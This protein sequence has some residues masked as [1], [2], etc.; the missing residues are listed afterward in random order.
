MKEENKVFIDIL[1]RKENSNKINWLNAIGYSVKFIYD[2]IED[3]LTIVNYYKESRELE[4]KYKDRSQKIKVHNFTNCQLGNV[5]GKYTSD[6]KIGIGTNLKDNKKDITIINREYRKN[7]M[8]QNQKWYK[9]HCNKDNYEGWM[10]ESSV[11]KGIGC[12]CCNGK[13]VVEGINDITTTAPWLIPYFQGGY[14]EAKLYTKNSGKKIFP[15]CLDCGRVKDKAMSISDIY[16]RHTIGCQCNDKKSYISK[17]V[18]N[19]LEQLKIDFE[20]EKKYDWCNFYNPFKQK[21]TYGIYD[22]VI[23]DMKL[24][25]E[26]DGGW[27]RK[28]NNISGQTKEESEWL[29]NIKDKLAYENG[30]KIIRISDD[31][32]V[33][34]NILDSDLSE[35]FDL[36][37]IDWNKCNEFALSNLIKQVC[38]YWNTNLNFTTKDISEKFNI[39]QFCVIEYLK[40]GS[41]LNWCNYDSKEE[42]R[43]NAPKNGEKTSKLIIIFKDD[44]LL[45]LFKSRSELERQ[46]EKLFGVRLI[47]SN[48]SHSCKFKNKYKEFHFKYV[49]ALTKEEYIKYEIKNKLKEL[50]NDKDLEVANF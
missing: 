13:I 20:V 40:K 39:S 8:N 25:I 29:D 16:K 21:D 35:L 45:G 27:H 46:S 44:I 2:N 47:G 48:I 10:V 18:F 23:E 30:Y 22:F 28:D 32:D 3:N 19:M 43:K 31:G 4:I 5:L 14:D 37:N 7:K 1:P 9:Y 33:K 34:Q 15:I 42:M 26:A 36:N 38:K 41:M 49:S 11:L 12:S 17:Y 24:I 6:F 50:N